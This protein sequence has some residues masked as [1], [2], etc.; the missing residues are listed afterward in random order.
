VEA[1]S[2]ELGRPVKEH[3]RA[4]TE[5][6]DGF[7]GLAILLVFGYHTWL[8]SWYTPQAPFDVVARTGYLGVDLFFVISGFCLFFP[9]AQRALL[10]APAPSAAT[11]AYR[12]LLKI[13]PSYL[14]V[15]AVTVAIASPA[16]PNA[17]EAAL[18]L[19]RHLFFVHSFWNEPFRGANSV[20]WSLGIEVQFYLVFPLI[21]ALFVRRPL[22]A[23]FGMIGIALA[24]RYAL[25]GCCLNLETIVR[26]LPA[27]LDLFALG[28]LAAYG[29][30]WS[31][32]R[33]PQLAAGNSRFAAFAIVLAVAAFVLLKSANAVQ[34]DTGGREIWGLAGRTAFGAV[35]AGLIATSCL[36]AAWW[37]ALIANPVLVFLSIVSYNLYLW[38]TLVA[39]WL[40]HHHLPPSAL[41]IAHDDP[42][43]RPWFV[44]TS[45]GVSLAIATV[46]TY[47]VERPLIA[48][49]RLR[50][51][52]ARQP[53]G[54]ATGNSHVNVAP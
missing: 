2:L 40:I 37:R 9:Y 25:A 34:Y 33:H 49:G 36:G 32:S 44:A 18:A 48:A 19:L 7:R 24:F 43:W 21:A 16:L 46:L 30:A 50:L 51:L 35:C 38:H 11:F 5:A 14:L 1:G 53:A 41:A 17:R 29:V 28:M 45:L 26:Q 52:G 42:A 13:L 8:F 23:A 27:F 31:R 54:A 12:R 39:L 4:G 20:L 6:V 3:A 15:L 47:F 10:G 22:T